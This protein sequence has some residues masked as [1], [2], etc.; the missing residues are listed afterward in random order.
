MG[1]FSQI[2]DM[3][4]G[5]GKDSTGEDSG[6]DVEVSRFDKCL[7]LYWKYFDQFAPIIHRQRIDDR[8]TPMLLA[9]LAAIGSQFC[10]DFKTRVWGAKLFEL[11]S[12]VP[13]AVSL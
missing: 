4:R 1:L 5:S 12:R 13:A 6:V 10:D 11:C 7:G 2:R 9:T 3:T 8:Q